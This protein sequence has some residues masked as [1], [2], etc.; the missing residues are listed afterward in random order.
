M[1]SD[2]DAN[3]RTPNFVITDSDNTNI[4]AGL[5]SSCAITATIEGT[6]EICAG[7]RSLVVVTGGNTF[8]WS[9][10][11][12][13]PFIY[14]NPMET[15]TYTV[16]VSDSAIPDCTLTLEFT[17]NVSEKMTIGDIVFEDSNRNGLR[18][19][20]EPGVDDLLVTL[21]HAAGDVAGSTVTTNGGA[22]S[23]NVCP[24]EYFIHFGEV[25][26][27]Y[28]FT[29]AD[30]G[31]DAIDSDANANGQT[32]NFLVTDSDNLTIDAGLV[33][34][35]SSNLNPAFQILPRDQP[36]VYAPGA[37]TAACIGDDLFLWMYADLQNL[38]DPLAEDYTEWTFTYEFPNGTVIVQNDL[39][40]DFGNNKIEKL[41]IKRQDFGEYT[42]SWISPEGCTG[43][44]AFT[45]ILSEVDC[46]ANGR[47]ISNSFMINAVYP[48]PAAAGSEITLEISNRSGAINSPAARNANNARD[49]APEWVSRKETIRV[50][51]YNF[52]GRKVGETQT[53][54]IEEGT[55]KVYYE[56]GNLASGTYVIK[57]DSPLWTDSELLI[58]E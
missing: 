17:V 28:T 52:D 1:D 44:T 30:A 36:G 29:N 56:L 6:S 15:T 5:V 53:F 49:N 14:V 7:D 40:N 51:L 22:Y 50:S 27:G 34:L 18:D 46:G 32:A 12:T 54:E 35:C 13:A 8:L 4:S 16:V 38:D 3:G 48:L 25:P 42:I 43:T 55:V 2:A 45:L 20:N 10:G 58:I 24:G 47:R 39:S 37:E 41:D 33:A 21:Y 23:F 57:V 31:D 11:A 19:A 26:I 9:T